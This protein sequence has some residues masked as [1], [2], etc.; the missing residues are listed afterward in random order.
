MGVI[1][2]TLG[3][4]PSTRYVR[5]GHSRPCV[6]LR[7]LHSPQGRRRF[8]VFVFDPGLRSWGATAFEG[9]FVVAPSRSSRVTRPFLCNLTPPSM[10]S[11]HTFNEL[12]DLRDR[13]RW[14]TDP[15]R[16][17]VIEPPAFFHVH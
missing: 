1:R 2:F 9:R 6:S 3:K 4:N 5:N 15:C 11:H 8:R 7:I 12:R 10:Q 16:K 14:G 13:E 17:S